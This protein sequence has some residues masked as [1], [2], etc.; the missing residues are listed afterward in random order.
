MKQK[1]HL[2]FAL[3]IAFAILLA[4]CNS[5]ERKEYYSDGV[6]KEITTYRKGVKDG[7]YI[8]YYRDGKKQKEGLYKDDK[9]DGVWR[10]WHENGR[11]AFEGFYYAGMRDSVWKWWHSNGQLS[12]E[13]FYK[14]KIYSYWVQN[15]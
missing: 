9:Q 5:E 8:S 2:P 11:L 10:E 14:G 7:P 3:F 12:K 4:A 15:C 13:E 6:L 1:I